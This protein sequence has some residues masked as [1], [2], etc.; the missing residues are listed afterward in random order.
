MPQ[1]TL[2]KNNSNIIK[3]LILTSVIILGTV[4]IYSIF[5]NEGV[6]SNIKSEFI[7]VSLDKVPVTVKAALETEYSGA[8]L[9]KAYVNEKKEYKLELSVGNQKAT[10]FTDVDG[11]W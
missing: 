1:V 3:I 10:V 5:E 2:L 6:E 7:E 9:V 11:N 4:S 8:K